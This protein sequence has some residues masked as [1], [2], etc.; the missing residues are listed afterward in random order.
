MTRAR[1]LVVDDHRTHQSNLKEY[2]EAHD[3]R[4]EVFGNGLDAARRL[5]EAHFDL[6]I[7]NVGLPW[8]DGL[9][10]C[11]MLRENGNGT[12][13]LMVGVRRTI[14]DRVESLQ[15]GADDYMIKPLSMREFGARVEAI[16]RRA[17]TG[18]HF[19]RVGDLELD[20][21]KCRAVRA[22]VPLH[23]S[24]IGLR[25]LIEL[26]R[27]SPAVVTR[28]QLEAQGWGDEIPTADSLRTNIYLLRQAVDK[29]FKKALIHT[30][31]GIGWALYD[32][33]Q[34]A[35]GEPAE[36]LEAPESV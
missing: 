36:A 12:P 15:A 5:M 7:L 2:F 6:I 17:K 11:R 13:V 35:D 16:L 30:R 28:Q 8:L 9:S 19:L 27:R 23:L 24:L 31:P 20:L 10:L 25:L 32:N 18:A 29:P 4:A 14:E 26:M 33:D 22:G 21:L 34:T 3:M 1:I